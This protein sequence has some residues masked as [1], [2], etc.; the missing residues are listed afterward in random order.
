MGSRSKGANRVRSMG[1]SRPASEIP[2]AVEFYRR[3]LSALADA[4]N[5]G[6]LPLSWDQRSL[7]ITRFTHRLPDLCDRHGLGCAS[8]YVEVVRRVVMKKRLEWFERDALARIK[9]ILNEILDEFQSMRYAEADAMTLFS[10]FP[11]TARGS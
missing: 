11:T 1:A 8:G 9:R 2:D 10:K 7:L 3:V 4:E 6:A 5:A